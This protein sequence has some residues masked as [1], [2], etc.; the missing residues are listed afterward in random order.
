V[1]KL[2]LKPQ[3]LIDK[4]SASEILTQERKYLLPLPPKYDTARIFERRVNKYSCFEVDSFLYSVPDAY[5]G[6]F[7]FVKVYPDKITAYYKEEEIAVHHRRYGQSEW[8]IDIEHYRQ[9]FLK[10]PGA[11]AN[12]LALLQAAPELKDIYTNY[13]IGSEKEFIELLGV[14]S[15]KGLDRVKDAIVKLERI[16]PGGINTDKIKMIVQR[17]DTKISRPPK[18]GS[19]IEVYSK[20][21]L[22]SYSSLLGSSTIKEANLL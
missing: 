6:Q 16:C 13:Y 17:N 19:Q 1:E 4:R 2:N 5:V 14:I 22:E 12:S 10:K 3:V 20:Q 18:N 9:T 15:D 8:A 11:L 21:I 7:V